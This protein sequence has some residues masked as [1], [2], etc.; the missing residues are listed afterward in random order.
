MV[1]VEE[2]VDK[3]AAIDGGYVMYE[4]LVA[5]EVWSSD[6]MMPEAKGCCATPGFLR[7]SPVFLLA[8]LPETAQFS[9]YP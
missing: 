4:L 1:S 5:P 6:H 3:Y 7:L 9:D 2:G 8:C